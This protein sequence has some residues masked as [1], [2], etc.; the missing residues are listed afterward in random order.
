MAD[1]FSTSGMIALIPDDPKALAVDGGLPPE[2]LHCTLT[3]LGDGV[4]QWTEERT[5]ALQGAVARLATNYGPIEARI[6][7]QS[8]WNADGGTNPQGEPMK[9]CVVYQIDGRTLGL[10]GL[11]SEAYALSEQI[12]GADYPEQHSPYLPH[13]AAAYDSTDVGALNAN[14]GPVTLGRIRLALGN[15]VQDFPLTGSTPV[16]L[17]APSRY[18]EGRTAE[19]AS[20]TA[21]ASPASTDAQPELGKPDENGQIPVHFPVL[22]VE[23][24]RTSDGRLIAP[25]A[26]EH[27]ALPMSILAQTKN[28]GADGGHAG[29]EVIGHLTTMERVP[30]PEVVSKKTGSPFPEGTFV[31]RGD[32][33]IDPDTAGG[34][35]A[36]DGHLR[37]NSV[38]LSEVDYEEDFTEADDR[39]INVTA[40]RIAATTLC[41]IPAFEDAYVEMGDEHD[42]APLPEPDAVVASA[43]SAEELGDHCLLCDLGEQETEGWTL[44]ADG[45]FSPTAAKRKRA[46]KKGLAIKGSQD[47]GGDASYPIENQADLD[48]A[49]NMVGLGK[50]PN[51]KI[52]AHIKAA[53]KKLGLKLPQSLTAS[54]AASLPPLGY[55]TDPGF[56]EPTPLTIDGDRITGHIATWRSCHIGVQGRC[57]RPPRS[58]SG[59][60]HYCNKAKRVVDSD[61]I[62][63]TIGIGNLTMNTSH[64][65]LTAGA[66]GALRHYD[67]TGLAVADVNAGEDAHGIWIAGTVRP[68][69]SQEDRVALLASAP[70]GDWRNVDGH[71]LDLVAVLQVNTPGYP[72]PRARIASGAPEAL[73]AAG[74]VRSA[75]QLAPPDPNDELADK[76]AAK[77]ADQWGLP[78]RTATEANEIQ[79]DMLLADMG[80]VHP[81]DLGGELAASRLPYGP[82]SKLWKYWTSGEGLARYIDK[83][84]PWTALRDALLSENVPAEMADGLTTNIM[85]ATPEGRAAFKAHHPGGRSKG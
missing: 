24:L 29:A 70:S 79:R 74:A 46:F 73:V 64:A 68:G 35:S 48:K 15:D 2:E 57:V 40:G 76:I 8:I 38:D 39:Q 17:E 58:P 22:V 11:Q 5:E 41:P 59:Y 32:G 75:A 44:T 12:M 30:G 34:K 37:G 60:A 6:F 7:A 82:G 77:L 81:F 3:F 42:G 23:G 69:L 51:G 78:S 83:A 56:T 84:H 47:D 67:H 27:R 33:L 45:E 85:L 31:W 65:E 66:S 20:K 80:V 55:F 19:M 54:A 36:K 61:G 50:D 13:I 16:E 18:T 4:D 72:V 71:G 21:T 53:A 25:G 43:F 9:P 14:P 26:L 28:P 62:E 10:S 49:A 1:D 52:K 63:R